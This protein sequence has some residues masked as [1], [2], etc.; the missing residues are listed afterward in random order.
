MAEY[1][2][3]TPCGYCEKP[4][5]DDTAIVIEHSGGE[6]LVHDG[7]APM[8]VPGRVV[9]GAP[10]S[11]EDNCGELWSIDNDVGPVTKHRVELSDRVAE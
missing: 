1:F 11:I 2:K 3:G 4:I 10:V 5:E 9:L 6:V 8:E 7:R